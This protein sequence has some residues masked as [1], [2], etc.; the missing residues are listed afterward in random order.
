MH[1]RSYPVTPALSSIAAIGTTYA[2]LLSAGPGPWSRP[3]FAIGMLAL[4]IATLWIEPAVAS[5][6]L[7]RLASLR[8]F[9]WAPVG[10]IAVIPAGTAVFSGKRYYFRPGTA[11][12][13]MRVWAGWWNCRTF[14]GDDAEYVFF[15]RGGSCMAVATGSVL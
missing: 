12:S 4:A 2:A 14:R 3:R 9:L 11:T 1:A 10:R 15:E 8:G 13:D 6:K 7:V 5:R